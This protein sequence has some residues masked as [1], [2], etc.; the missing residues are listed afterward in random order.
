[1]EWGRNLPSVATPPRV[2]L[3]RFRAVV[4]GEREAHR[5]GQG[6]RYRDG[7]G[8]LVGEADKRTQEIRLGDG[9]HQ[10]VFTD[11]W[12]DRS[13]HP[14]SRRPRSPL[15]SDRHDRARRAAHDAFGYAPQEELCQPR[16]TVSSHDD[17]AGA[18]PASSAHDLLRRNAFQQEARCSYAGLLGGGHERVQ[19]PLG[20]GPART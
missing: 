2:C 13:F 8:Q 14:P 12:Q 6:S 4:A 17:H 16:A 7:G 18:P 1:M 10:A 19:T 20:L 11:H 3:R 5:G 9:A 15:G